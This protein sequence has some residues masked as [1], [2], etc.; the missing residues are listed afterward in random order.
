MIL[1]LCPHA[2]PLAEG[3][4]SRSCRRQGFLSVQADGRKQEVFVL[5]E[6]RLATP[7]HQH[8]SDGIVE[9]N[10]FTA[11]FCLYLAELIAHARASDG[12]GLRPGAVSVGL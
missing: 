2:P 8:L 6:Q 12:G 7:L 4:P 10:W 11:R 3:N 9:C 5:V 1:P